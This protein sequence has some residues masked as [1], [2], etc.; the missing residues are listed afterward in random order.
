MDEILVGVIETAK[1]GI[2]TFDQVLKLQKTAEAK[3]QSLG[4][5]AANGQRVLNYLYKKPYLNAE[6]VKEITGISMPSCY[7]L[8]SDLE[9]L[10]ILNEFTGGQRGRAY[11]FKD[12]LNLF[13]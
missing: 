13:R 9:E 10:E 12:Y 11:L 1:N 2:D 5:R 8:I 4:S 7:K 3:V 6:I